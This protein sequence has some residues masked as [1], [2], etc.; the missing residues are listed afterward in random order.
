RSAKDRTRVCDAG[1]HIL[2][3]TV[4]GQVLAVDA[5]RGYFVPVSGSGAGSRI[6]LPDA[7]SQEDPV[8]GVGASSSSARH[9]VVLLSSGTVLAIDP[10]TGHQ[11]AGVKAAA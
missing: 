11:V 4:R 3:S 10:H 6:P 7:V 9:L 2:L 5:D 8:V 1:D